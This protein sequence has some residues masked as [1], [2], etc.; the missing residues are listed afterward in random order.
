M[1]QV[2]PAPMDE[3]L[4]TGDALPNIPKA[5]ENFQVKENNVLVE[6]EIEKTESIAAVS[7][8]GSAKDDAAE[9]EEDMVCSLF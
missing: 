2:G 9:E 3:D 1:A 7:A 4:E 5:I 6:P 8:S